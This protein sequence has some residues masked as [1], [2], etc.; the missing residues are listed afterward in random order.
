MDVLVWQL[1]IAG[2]TDAFIVM[3]LTTD[4]LITAEIFQ[5]TTPGQNETIIDIK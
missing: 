2:Y 5:I 1:P 4:K 3:V